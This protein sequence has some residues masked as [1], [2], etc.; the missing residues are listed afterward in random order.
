[1]SLV[2]SLLSRVSV[3][4]VIEPS[5]T[6]EELDLM[7]RAGLRACDHGRLKPYRFILLEGEARE[8]LGEATG[9]FLQADT[10]D[11]SATIIEAAKNKALRAPTLLAVI[12]SARDSEKIPETEQLIS[13]GCAAQLIVTAAHMLGIGAVWRTGK[14]IYSDEVGACLQLEKN[15]RVVAMLYLGRPAA[16]VPEPP[17]VDPETFL[18]RL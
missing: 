2:E 16:K 7:L 11:A 18:T 15:E 4:R 1:M 10:G 17:E 6:A 14:A 9:G 3:P 8:R 12:L 13:A 5:V